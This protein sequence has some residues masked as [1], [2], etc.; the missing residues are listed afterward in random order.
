LIGA[1]LLVIIARVGTMAWFMEDWRRDLTQNHAATSADARN[2]LLRPILMQLSPVDAA[3]LVEQAA[4]SL[5]RWEVTGTEEIAAGRLVRLV[6]T[7]PMLRFKDDITVRLVAQ[8]APDGQAA[9][10]L[11][12]ESQ[13]RLGRADFGQNPRNLVEIL[14]GVREL[15]PV[16]PAAESESLPGR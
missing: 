10:L 5:T 15:L 4:S 11:T 9:T 13:S 7:T 2:P 3:R 1:I 14:T 16:E 12:A 6:R 8:D